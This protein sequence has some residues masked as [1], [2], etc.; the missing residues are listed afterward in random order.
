MKRT[1]ACVLVVGVGALAAACDRDK[2]D[3]K[4]TTTTTSGETKPITTAEKQPNTAPIV[5]DEKG[6]ID[7]SAGVNNDPNVYRRDG[8]ASLSPHDPHGVSTTTTTG[9][10][11]DRKQESSA[12]PTPAAT[13]K[14]PNHTT[15]LG[16]GKSGTYTG[17]KGT[18]GGKKTW[19]TGAGAE[20]KDGGK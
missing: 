4:S 3:K 5:T 10:D 9:A 1:M 15:P 8:G 16:D 7:E 13:N 19:G 18:Y 14:D 6:R 20:R 17:D 11:F 2:T 12:S